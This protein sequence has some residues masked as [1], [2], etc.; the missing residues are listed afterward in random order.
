MDRKQQLMQEAIDGELSAAKAQEL[1]GYLQEDS[2]SLQELDK[3]QKVDQ[4]L[5]VAPHRRAPERL[6][7][8]IIARIAEEA[9]KGQRQQYD[10]DE[11]AEAV[12]Q[13]AL[14]AVTVATLPLLVAAAELMLNA[15]A[16][17]ETIERVLAKVTALFILTI[18]VMDVMLEEAQAAAENDPEA[19]LAVL[20]MIP[21]TLLLLVKEVLGIED[22]TTDE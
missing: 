14:N 6:A 7:V 19:A 1:D 2:E 3:L 20:T 4:L 15:K 16:K 17:P 8:N 12:V 10:L 5:R 11:M 9:R 18:D 22:E 13:V 21:S